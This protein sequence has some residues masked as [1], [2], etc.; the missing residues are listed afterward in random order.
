MKVARLS[1][2]ALAAFTPRKYSWYSLL[3]GHAVE[4]LVEALWYKLVGCGF[5]S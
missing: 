3:L 4:Q 1:A 2:Y 5:S